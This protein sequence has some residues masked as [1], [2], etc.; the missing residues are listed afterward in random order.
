MSL[1]DLNLS[2]KALCFDQ[3]TGQISDPAQLFYCRIFDLEVMNSLNRKAFLGLISLI[4]ILALLVFLPA[5]TLDYWQGWTFLFVFSIP[6]VGITL[7]LMRYD[8]ELLARRVEAGPLAEK[9]NNQKIIQL[10]ASLAFLSLFVVSTLDHRFHWS[11]VP[12]ALVII[13]DL[14]VAL[15]LL[16]IFFVFRVNTFASATV[17]VGKGQRVI[18]SGLYALVRHP[19]Y[20]SAIVML[21]GVPLSLGSLWGL[22][23]MLALSM[24]IVWR[25]LDEERVLRNSLTGYKD[26]IEKVK[27]RLIPFVW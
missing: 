9:E 23:P 2:P 8:P 1:L 25:L 6:I 15:G 17:G 3:V 14:L 13:G 27:Y 10:V 5:W 4:G 19:M 21:L 24:V 11:S 26:Y 7:Y 12:T 18:S 16:G 20:S 22:L